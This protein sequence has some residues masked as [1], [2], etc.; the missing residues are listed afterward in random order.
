MVAVYD[1]HNN[2][3]YYVN[4]HAVNDAFVSSNVHLS[5]V[6]NIINAIT[7]SYSV[8]VSNKLN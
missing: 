6:V 1:L 7:E 5:S 4:I 8:N 3:P 2:R